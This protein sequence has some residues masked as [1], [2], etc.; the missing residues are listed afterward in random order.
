M[1]ATDEIRTTGRLVG[2]VLGGGVGLVEQVHRAIARRVFRAVGP[3]SWPVRLVHDAI[4]GAVYGSVRLAHASLPRAGAAYAALGVDPGAPALAD[5]RG[6]GAALAAVNGL[7]GDSLAGR[8]PALASDMVIREAGATVSPDRDGL[9]AAFGDA[10]PRVAV[11][12]HGLCENERSWERDA[13]RHHGDA[14]A[15]YGSLLQ[16]DLGFTPVVL[17]YNTGLRVSDNG[18]ALS[19]LLAGLVADW[20]V[21]VEQLVLVGHSM[22]GLVVRSACR[23]AELEGLGWADRVGHVVCLGTPH[24]GAPLEKGVNALSWLAG[25]VPETRPF[26]EV[27]NARSVGVKDLRFGA[28]V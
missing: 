9:A 1:T 5:R 11:F 19:D 10:G 14:S 20:P 18:R 16:R 21:A 3:T 7:W 8:Y 24:L 28:C 26:A 2:D 4:G 13:L 25:R 15:T 6:T 12:V 17:R 22:G 27:L 23:R